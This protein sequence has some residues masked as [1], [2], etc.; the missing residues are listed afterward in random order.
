MQRTSSPGLL[1]LFPQ[2]PVGGKEEREAARG[3]VGSGR[4]VAEQ[5]L[6]IPVGAF[7]WDLREAGS[8]DEQH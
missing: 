6:L 8:S 4:C 2:A 7:V 1:G 3:G 5:R